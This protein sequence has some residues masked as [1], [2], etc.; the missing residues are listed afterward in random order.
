MELYAAK[1]IKPKIN[2]DY[3]SENNTSSYVEVLVRY[4]EK[5]KYNPIADVK[6]NIFLNEISGENLIGSITT[7]TKGKGKFILTEI[8]DNLPD[9]IS[10]LKIIAS[11]SNHPKYKNKKK[12]ISIL[13]S[14]LKTEIKQTDSLTR[15]TFYFTNANVESTGLEGEAVKVYVSRFLGILPIGDEYA[16]TDENGM[17]TVTIPSDIPQDINGNLVII[18]RVE[19]HDEYGNLMIEKTIKWNSLR[20]NNETFQ[21]RTLWASG[22]KT[23]YWLLVS[24]NIMIVSVWGVLFYLA[25]LLY[26]IKIIGN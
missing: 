24:S 2:L 26:K 10:S 3:Y 25:F 22:D 6:I 14:F 17:L 12:R 20:N 1:K 7:D 4:R 16:T 9:S 23:P 15:A 11:L 8:W 18:G 13:K 19:D 21:E 5:K